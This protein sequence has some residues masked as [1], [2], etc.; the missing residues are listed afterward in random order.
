MGSTIA[1]L[2]ATLPGVRERRRQLEDE[3]AAVV[4]QENAMVSVL[5][6]LEA[7]AGTSLAG[8]S[9]MA[10]TAGRASAEAVETAAGPDEADAALAPA[11]PGGIADVSATEKPEPQPTPA[12]TARR[13]SDASPAQQTAAKKTPA[14]KT[15]SKK[16]ATA[17]A[18]LTGA[19]KQ[20][21]ATAP[22][23][24]K[25][26]AARGAT[27]KTA[28]KKTAA[29][30]AAVKTTVTAEPT[31]STQEQTASTPAVASGRRRRTDAKSV[32]AVLAD[33]HDSLRARQV[34]DLLGLDGSDSDVNA[35]RTTLERLAKN[36]TAQRTGRGLYAAVSG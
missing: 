29:K 28:V 35:V 11:E 4:A 34:A 25:K 19:P 27:K 36:G 33:A 7:L 24:T 3:L 5:Q 21:A 6:G 18:P 30:K 9:A 12:K 31:P 32:L 26:T 13:R 20:D 16:K 10:A 15:P 17:S 2:E 1:L 22:A 14:R 8:R 23:P